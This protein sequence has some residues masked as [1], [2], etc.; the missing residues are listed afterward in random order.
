MDIAASIALFAALCL[1]PDAFPWLAWG[2]GA[3]CWFTTAARIAAAAGAFRDYP[4][5]Q[6]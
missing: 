3:L 6:L 1:F 2:F 5:T 4:R